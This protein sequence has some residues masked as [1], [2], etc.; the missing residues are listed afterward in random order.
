LSTEA[1]TTAD[2]GDTIAELVREPTTV[3]L[4]EFSAVTW[5]A[6]RIHYDRDY[7][8][9]V[10]GYPNVLVQSH[11]HACFLSQAVMN[12]CGPRARLTRIGWQNRGMAVPGDQLTVSGSVTAVQRDGGSVTVEF[13]LEER[14][15]H[16]Q[17]CV[18]GWATAVFPE[19]AD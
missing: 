19:G 8:R 5:N 10:E 15:Q 2:V 13:A 1:I 7:A 16:D 17:L 18:K 9:D 14:N 11:L 12:A 3:Q 4:F 6:H